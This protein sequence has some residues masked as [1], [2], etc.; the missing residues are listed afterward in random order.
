MRVANSTGWIV[1][2]DVNRSVNSCQAFDSAG[3]LLE[4]LRVNLGDVVRLQRVLQHHLPVAREVR[5]PRRGVPI[6]AAVALTSS[7]T[8]PT[9]SRSDRRLSLRLTNTTSPQVSTRNRRRQAFSRSHGR[10]ARA[11]GILPVRPSLSNSQPWYWHRSR[12]VFP[13]GLLGELGCGGAG[14]R[15]GRHAVRRRKLRSRIG[16]SSRSKV[17]KSPGLARSL[18]GRERV[19][20][21]EEQ[22]S[23]FG[24]YCSFEVY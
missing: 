1:L 3:V 12:S 18:D 9:Q 17:R 16:V 20:R 10:N 4:R 15:S 8:A 7:H 19:P 22:V 11:S 21:R 14:R 24:R 13:H 5:F 2:N 23:E 6:R